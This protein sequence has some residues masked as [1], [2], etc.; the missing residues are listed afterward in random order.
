MEDKEAKSNDGVLKLDFDSKQIT[1]FETECQVCHQMASTNILPTKIA[2]F[3]EILV[4]AFHCDH[5]GFRQNEIDP[6]QELAP[7]GIHFVL[8]VT[9]EKDMNR[10]VVKTSYASI[11]IPCCGLEIP[12]TAQKGKISTVEGFILTAKEQFSQ[13]LE[14]GYYSE[15]GDEFIEKITQL[16]KDLNEVLDGKKFPFEFILDDP[17]GN[18]FIENPFAPQTDPYIKVSFFDRTKEMC[19]QMGYSFENQVL[20][21]K[22]EIKE[23]SDNNEKKETKE[24]SEFE[25]KKEKEVRSKIAYYNKKKDFSVYK[26]SSEMSKNIIDFTEG[27]KEDTIPND[28]LFCMRELCNVCLKEG[29]IRTC[30]FSIPYFKELLISCFKC[31]Y[32]GYKNVDV[33]GGGGISEKGTKLTL[34]VEK[35]EDLNRDI[36]KSDTAKISIPEIGF[37]SSEGSLGSMFTTVEGIVDKIYSQLK[38]NPFASGDSR[39]NDEMVNFIKKVKALKELK[40]PFTLILDDPLSNS[41]IFSYSGDENP[42]NDKNLTKEIYERTFE[43]NEDLGINDMKVENYAEEHNDNQEDEKKVNKRESN[44]I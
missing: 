32:C 12:T 6:A 10:R 20:E 15:M 35:Q 43:Q 9:G 33:R 22:K 38:D 40:S 5:C 27:M 31:E 3:K 24:K 44:E 4:F 2:F 42:D 36:F 25:L 34:K 7:Q 23:D 37:D 41:F 30:I 28:K 21:N 26:S 11:N 17:S 13:C 18:S 14:E 39:R 29:E 1:H 8:Q 16:I 19:E